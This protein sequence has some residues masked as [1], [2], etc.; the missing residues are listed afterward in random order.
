MQVSINTG[1]YTLFLFIEG[2]QEKDNGLYHFLFR[3]SS[4][5][6][7]AEKEKAGRG[8]GGKWMGGGSG[9]GDIS[10]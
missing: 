4:A 9:G 10:R 2:R 5:K 8:W 3:P 7:V 6:M 1:I